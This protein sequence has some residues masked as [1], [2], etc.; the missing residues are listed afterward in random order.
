MQLDS[1]HRY[2]TFIQVLTVTPYHMVYIGL[3]PAAASSAAT[4]VTFAADFAARI[5]IAARDVKVRFDVLR[6]L[7]NSSIR[8]ESV[9]CFGLLF[10]Q[11]V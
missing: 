8:Y 4:N 5:P 7:E 3:D 11:T 9:C 1:I 2:P 6:E 10:R